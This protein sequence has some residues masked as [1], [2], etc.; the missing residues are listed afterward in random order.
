ML[1]SIFGWSTS[2]MRGCIQWRFSSFSYWKAT[3]GSAVHAK[4]S[5][6]CAVRVIS[7]GLPLNGAFS[8]STRSRCGTLTFQSP[9]SSAAA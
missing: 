1:P 4:P 7:V 6:R 3:A 9:L 8:I 5:K 2:T